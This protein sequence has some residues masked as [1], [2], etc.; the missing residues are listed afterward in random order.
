MTNK[1]HS[2]QE[3]VD[4][5]PSWRQKQ[6]QSNACVPIS[7][8]RDMAIPTE[9]IEKIELNQQILVDNLKRSTQPT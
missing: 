9:S 3:S 8:S 6:Q 1:T 5:S 4:G 7:K 2:C